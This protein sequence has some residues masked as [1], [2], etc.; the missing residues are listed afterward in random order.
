M[1]WLDVEDTD[2][3]QYWGTDTGVSQNFIN[4]LVQAATNAV[5]A[6]RVG[7]YSSANN[8]N[9][10]FQDTS[11]DCCSSLPIWFARYDNN[12]DPNSGFIPFGGWSTPT[13]KQFAGDSTVCG[14]D[15]DL[16]TFP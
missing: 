2:S 3:H 4:A 11:Y 14:A 13:A 12:P 16:S 10:I 6:S 15:V 1:V 7:I 9:L 8:W 5:G